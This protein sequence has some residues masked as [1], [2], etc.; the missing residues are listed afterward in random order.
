MKFLL[1]LVLT[2]IIVAF[3]P[4]Y[5]TEEPKLA[6]WIDT[7][8]TSRPIWAD[9]MKEVFLMAERSSA[10][11]NKD[12]DTD[13]AAVFERIFKV[14]KDDSALFT[15]INEIEGANTPPRTGLKFVSG[16]F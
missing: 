12:S 14:K 9:T 7:S 3:T 13:F 15:P 8:C 11:L 1:Y 2:F 16:K 5:G 10:R 6:Y 4:C